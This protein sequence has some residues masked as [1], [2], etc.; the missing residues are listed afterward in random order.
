MSEPTVGAG[1]ARGLFELAVAKG[2]PRAA[3]AEASGVDPRALEDPDARVPFST[4]KAIMRAG[5]ALSGDSAL[6]LHYGEGV[7][8]ADVSIAGLI[9]QAAETM[10]EA[11]A[12]LNRYV[13][14]IV[15]A[16][17]VGATE[18]F[19]LVRDRKGVWLTDTRANPNDFPELTESAFAQLVCG[20]RRATGFTFVKAVHVTHPEP[21]HAAEY[22]RIFQSPVT[23]NSDRNAMEVHEAA[24]NLRIPATM[25]RYVF[26][27]L[28]ERAEALLRELE[29]ARSTR[30]KVE[31][32][33]MPV[34]HKGEVN[35][36][37]I[38]SEL[39]MSR[40]TLFR[41]LRA[42]GVTFVGVLDE[43]RRT[44]A[45]HYLSGKKVSVNETAYLVG[46]SD[47]SA[48]SR[49]FKRW[50]GKPPKVAT[51]IDS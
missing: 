15:E 12:Q 42:E 9:S 44:L 20:A 5:K 46:F 25:N 17:A 47:P 40:Q 14:L 16:E 51:K 24:A 48:F 35:M 18:R 19:Q 37:A 1:F 3:L 26:G 38:A 36:D 41:K 33:L 43:L 22:E 50:T 27:V 23:F 21:P 29:S 6:G 8:I 45:L 39:G 34:L 28:S 32:L 30:G 31:K 13:R 10:D 4:Y 11:L 7:D 2:A 49:A